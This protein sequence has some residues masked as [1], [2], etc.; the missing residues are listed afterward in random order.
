MLDVFVTAD[1]KFLGVAR[2]EMI[3]TINPERP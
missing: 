2:Q 1:D 3:H